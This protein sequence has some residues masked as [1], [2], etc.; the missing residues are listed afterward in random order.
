MG[1]I[2]TWPAP[3]RHL[4]LLVLSTGLAWASTDGIDWLKGQTGWGLLAAALLATLL[5]YFTPL[6][7]SYGVGKTTVNR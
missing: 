1:G 5:A 2:A 4:V 3:I 7:N 6:V